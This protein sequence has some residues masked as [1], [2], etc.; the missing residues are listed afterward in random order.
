MKFD[1]T[2]DALFVDCSG[3]PLDGL[4]TPI[5]WTERIS[6]SADGEELLVR[7]IE[8]NGQPRTDGPRRFPKIFDDPF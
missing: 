8:L 3:T 5:H 4:S 6:V 7:R 2:E 1:E